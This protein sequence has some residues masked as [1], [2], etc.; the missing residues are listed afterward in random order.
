MGHIKRSDLE[1]ALVAI[2]DSKTFDRISGILDGII[3]QI[4]NLRLES[5]VLVTLR[6]TLLPKLMNGD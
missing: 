4:I 1:N 5:K 3:E 6:D 2:P